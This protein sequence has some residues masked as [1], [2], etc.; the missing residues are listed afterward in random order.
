MHDFFSYLDQKPN[1][2]PIFT[3]VFAFLGVMLSA[4]LKMICDYLINKRTVKADLVAKSRIEWIQEVR[5]LTA[6]FITTSTD[7]VFIAQN[8]TI[9]QNRDDELKFLRELDDK[10]VEA[11]MQVNLLKLYIPIH[12]AKGDL[13]DI[14][15]DKK[16]VEKNASNNNY[17]F[18]CKNIVLKLHE[19]RKGIVASS[20]DDLEKGVFVAT[21]ELSRYSSV[22]LKKEWEKATSIK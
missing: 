21:E 14:N 10:I 12:K 22:Y 4:I 2:I 17:I 1:M 11:M 6:D 13:T 20:K 19:L 3:G 7:A 16:I 18:Y 15:D 9:A 5:K 8:Y